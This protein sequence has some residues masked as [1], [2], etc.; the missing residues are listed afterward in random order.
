MILSVEQLSIY[1]PYQGTPH[2]VV[3][4]LSFSISAGEM[5]GIVGES[6][7]GKSLT[8]LALM[9]LLPP[10]GRV[11]AKRL[12]LCGQDLLPLVSQS[13]WQ[14]VRGRRV[15]MIFQ[16]PL[17]ALN[18]AL[19]V[20]DQL[21]EALRL[22]NPG[23]SAAVVRQ[24]QLE[25]LHQ[26][27]IASP[28]TRIH[29]YP[30][31]LSGGMAQRVMI[32]MALALEPALLIA[33]EPTTALDTTTQRQ[34]MDLLQRIREERRMAMLLVSHDIGLIGSCADRVQVMYSGELVESGPAPELLQRPRHPYTRGLIASQPGAGD[35]P[36]KTPLP[37]ITG[38]VPPLG[39]DIPGCRFA[40]RC[41]WFHQPCTLPQELHQADAEPKVMVRCN[42]RGEP[43]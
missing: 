20:G 6:G 3:R 15:A 42:R 29:A 10:G 23:C 4:D 11:S 39:S 34:I 16:N 13:D 9:G 31:E 38:S 25:L 28:Q 22:A 12:E 26:V 41:P 30:H 19:T 18:P 7:C 27:G 2:R 40:N 1:L 43:A 36:R 32:A 5:L 14:P 24:M 8:N 17:S 33:D 37:A 35:R 21:A